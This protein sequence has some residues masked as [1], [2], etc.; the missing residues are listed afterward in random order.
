MSHLDDDL[1]AL[2]AL[3]ERSPDSESAAHLELCERCRHEL[4]ELSRVVTAGR[5]NAEATQ[6][7]VPP[8]AHVWAGIAA[9][10]GISSSDEHRQPIAQTPTA[11]DEPTRLRPRSGRRHLHTWLAVA[12]GVAIGMSGTV[13]IQALDSEEP[14]A[15]PQ[16]DLIATAR[17]AKLG[18]TG[19]SGTAEIRDTADARILRVQLDSRTAGGGFREVWLLDAATGELVSLGVLNGTESTFEL[20]DGLDLRDYPTIDISR[21][22][23]DGDPAHS[24]DSIARGDLDL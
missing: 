12:A 14:T 21:E 3:G 11:V 18:A 1:L 2:L 7:L 10:V 16:N 6:Q 13:A 19:T 23:L 24:T 20:P 8:A 15:P 4:H 17:L 22:P 9:A 5:T